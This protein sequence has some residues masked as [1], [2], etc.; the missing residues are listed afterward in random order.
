MSTKVTVKVSYLAQY[1]LL[2]VINKI[3]TLMVGLGKFYLVLHCQWSFPH[4]LQIIQSFLVSK[5]LIIQYYLQMQTHIR[6]Y[7]VINYLCS[8]GRLHLQQMCC[9]QAAV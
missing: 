7:L 8:S 5:H 4:F 3:P 2:K 6:L 9:A 1:S